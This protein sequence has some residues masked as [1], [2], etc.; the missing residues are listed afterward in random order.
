MFTVPSFL[1]VIGINEGVDLAL[2]I[3]NTLFFLIVSIVLLNSFLTILF[4]F[5][6]LTASNGSEYTILQGK[7]IIGV[8]VLTV[9]IDG[10]DWISSLLSSFLSSIKI[11]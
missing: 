6:A 3:S 11:N 8:N 4:A 5:N 1:G 10:L 7:L 9:V 2:E